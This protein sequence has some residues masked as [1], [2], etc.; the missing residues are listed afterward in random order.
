MASR[1]FCTNALPHS[2]RPSYLRIT[3]QCLTESHCRHLCRM[4][5]VFT[6]TEGFR[7]VRPVQS[8][9]QSDDIMKERGPEDCPLSSPPC[10]LRVMQLADTPGEVNGDTEVTAVSDPA[11]V[12]IAAML[13]ARRGVDRRPPIGPS[14]KRSG[15][16]RPGGEAD[17]VDWFPAFH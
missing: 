13:L 16:R 9:V 11:V 17:V 14:S 8:R 5:I 15:W 4:S 6:A 2:D 1:C 7:G 3:P 12:Q 10:M